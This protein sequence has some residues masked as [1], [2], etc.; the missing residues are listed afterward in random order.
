M[1]G[2]QPSEMEAMT[3]WSYQA[4]LWNWNDRHNTGEDSEQVEPPSMDDVMLHFARIE[5]SGLARSIH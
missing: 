4:R 5:R 3:W 2:I 1:M